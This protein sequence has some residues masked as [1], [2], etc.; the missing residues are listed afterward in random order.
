VSQ[1]SPVEGPLNAARTAQRAVPT[2]LN[3]YYG[4]FVVAAP[5]RGSTILRRSGVL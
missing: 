2:S 5:G 4:S 1:S 3:T